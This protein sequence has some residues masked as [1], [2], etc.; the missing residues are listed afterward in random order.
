MFQIV[1]VTFPNIG[2]GFPERN[3]DLIAQ[4]P[5]IAGTKI[6]GICGENPP[7]QREPI[8]IH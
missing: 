2:I 4:I 3:A 5:Q 7:N 6:C 1:V 8:C